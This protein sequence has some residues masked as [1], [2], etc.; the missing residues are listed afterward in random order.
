MG[1]QVKNS[2][3]RIIARERRLY[4]MWL[5]RGGYSYARIAIEIIRA[6]TTGTMQDDY[7]G[8]TLSEDHLIRNYNN[9]KAYKDV[10][11]TMKQYNDQVNPDI[12]DERDD[13]SETLAELLSICMAA[14]RKGDLYGVQVALQSVQTKAKLLGVNKPERKE[15]SGPDGA[16]IPIDVIRRA[17][18]AADSEDAD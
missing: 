6:C 7:D 8:P 18:E 11:E 3:R 4:V 9:A 5:K 17:T 10:R 14:A 15:L 16:A 12:E 2:S 1:A 13:L